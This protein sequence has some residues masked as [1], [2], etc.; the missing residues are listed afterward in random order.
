ML[1]KYIYLL[2]FTV[3]VVGAMNATGNDSVPKI[4]VI[5]CYAGDEVYELC[6]HTALRIQ[7]ANGDFAV[8]YGLFDFDSP[9]FVYRFVK[10]ETDYCV[11]AYPFSHFM[12]EYMYADRRVV[13][14]ELA[15]SPGQAS[16]VVELIGINLRPENRVYRYNY[17]KNNCATRPI[18]IV[19]R[20]IGDTISFGELALPDSRHWTFR[21]EMRYFHR[22]YPWY[23]FGIDLALGVGLD[24]ELPLREKMFA[25]EALEQMLATAT[26]A[27]STGSPKPLVANTIV[28]NEGRVGGSQLPPTPWYLTPMTVCIVLLLLVLVATL[29]DLRRRRVT[30]WVDAAVFAIFGLMGS[31]LTFL[32]FVSVHEATSPNY[33]YVWLNPLCFVPAALIWLKKCKLLLKCYHFVNFA[34]LIV[35]M[36]AW[37]HLGQSG[38]AAFLPLMLCSFFRSASYLYINIC[39]KKTV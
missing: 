2:W 36:I 14:Q 33:L 29:R 20:A 18:E 31:L 13:E 25:P 26:V 27:D 32:I 1:K 9:N 8:N 15:L 5:T 39:A 12:R 4:S 10:G 21:D 7:T 19:E 30:K 3:F 22:N 6:G 23:Q 38:N 16:R 24:Y 35:L 28:L 37:H 11:G 34:S 17:V